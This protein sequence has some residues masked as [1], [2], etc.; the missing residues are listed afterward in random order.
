[1][2]GSAAAQEPDAGQGL[3]QDVNETL[4]APVQDHKVLKAGA[5][6]T[7]RLDVA[8]LQGLLANAPMEASAPSTANVLL[9]LP[10]PEGGFGRFLVEESLIMEDKLAAQ[11]PELR[12]YRGQ[13]LDD[14]TATVRFD[15]TPAGFH[16]MVLSSRGTLFV[17]PRA[18]GDSDHYVAYWKKDYE[19][20]VPSDFRCHVSGD[21]NV[22]PKHFGSEEALL[23]PGG[24]LQRYRLAL[25]ATGEYT[26]FHGGTVAG[27]MSAITTTMNRV[28]GVYERELAVRMVLVANNSSIVYTNASTDPYTNNDGGTM[29]GQNQSNLD[30]VIG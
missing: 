12:T 24:T 13:G 28:N 8:G 21:V 11:F 2:S 5:Y 6:R 15:L 20:A 18:K 16:A 3:W 26:A 22:A 4:L 9:A 25:A 10:L 7:L 1:M 30:S 27:A 23:S 14:P 29:L 19:R 17:D